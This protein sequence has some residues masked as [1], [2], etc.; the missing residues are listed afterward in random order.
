[1]TIAPAPRFEENA[2]T[3]YERQT[4]PSIPGNR[5]PLRFE[6]GIASD[7]DVPS[8][9]TRGMREAAIPAPG[10]P[11]HVNPEQ[12]FKHADETMSERAHVGSAAW[13]DAPSLLGEFGHGAM[14][15]YAQQTYEQVDR[16]GGRYERRAPAT[17]RD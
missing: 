16:S 8:D 14:N 5:G 7:T 2:G 9:F 17:V 4:A 10:R 12:L 1:M 6:E 15:D 13:I 3:T 11:N